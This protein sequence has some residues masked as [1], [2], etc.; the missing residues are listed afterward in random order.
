MLVV[1][2]K[3][4]SGEQLSM[5]FKFVS[6][7]AYTTNGTGNCL[8]TF[9]NFNSLEPSSGSFVTICLQSF[10]IKKDEIKQN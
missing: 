8:P 4:L 5:G 1:D 3:D 7:S 9:L 2:E 10:Y 6:L